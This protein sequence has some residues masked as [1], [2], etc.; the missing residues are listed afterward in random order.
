MKDN[1]LNYITSC[2]MKWLWREY[3]LNMI[4]AIETLLT[5]LDDAKRPL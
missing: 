1:L 3:V 4:A 5:F 2:D